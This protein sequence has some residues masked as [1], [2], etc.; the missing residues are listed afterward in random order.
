MRR[1][2]S[3]RL[4][5]AALALYPLAYRRRY[6]AEIDALL[7]DTG[8]SPRV[9]ADLLRGALAAHLRPS[10]ALAGELDPDERTRLGIGSILLCWV[11]FAAAGFGLYKTTDGGGFSSAGDSHWLLGGAHLAIQ[12]L[13]AVATA[14]VLAGACPLALA[15]LRQGR[16]QPAVHRATLLA[17]RCMAALV[18]A[19]AGLV[20]LANANPAVSSSVAAVVFAT[21]AALGLACSV[22]CVIAARRSLAAL[23]LRRSAL[24][25]PM[26]AADGLVL[27]MLAIAVATAV[28]L[29]ALLA[30]A[31]GLAA[32]ANGPLGL[33]SVGLS[34]ALQ[35]VVMLLAVASALLSAGRSREFGRRL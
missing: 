21:W 25:E 18:A 34:V 19:S 15:A 5:R 28:Y 35:L 17:A 12:V 30:A 20:V 16:E 24:R 22:G 13:A 33:A 2:M 32:Q 8:T 7:E 27:A 23:E 6:G 10:A 11:L 4:T 26:L 14:L 9:V 1:P 31:P 29:V 3:A